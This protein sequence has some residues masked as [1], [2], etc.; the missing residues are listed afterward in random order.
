MPE[1]MLGPDGYREMAEPRLQ[2]LT[3]APADDIDPNAGLLSE[4]IQ[5]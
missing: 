5:Q 3:G 4:R 2:G 1:T